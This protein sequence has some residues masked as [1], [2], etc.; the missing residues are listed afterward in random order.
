MCG[1]ESGGTL[2]IM[3]VENLSK[4]AG[5]AASSQMLERAG[6][7]AGMATMQETFPKKVRLPCI[8]LP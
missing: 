8:I 3:H 1:V 2:Q 5:D 7:N 4:A 6:F